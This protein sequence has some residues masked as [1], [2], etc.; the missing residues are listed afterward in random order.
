[1]N[2]NNELTKFSLWKDY[3]RGKVVFQREG[4]GPVFM[5]P[6]EARQKADQSEELVEPHFGPEDTE[7]LHKLQEDLREYADDIEDT[8]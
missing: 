5:S 3:E 1:M 8:L 7:E 4:R 2:D 6:D